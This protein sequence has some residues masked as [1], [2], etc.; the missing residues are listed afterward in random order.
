MSNL[1]FPPQPKFLIVS[2]RYIGDVL[3]ST[4]LALSIKTQLPE[5]AVDYL[6][7]KGTEGILD[8]NP[9]VRK[10]HTVSS[11]PSGVVTFLKLLRR[12]D[13]AIGVNPSDRTTI[14]TAGA[15]RCSIGFSY[16]FGREWWKKK[17]LTQ[18]RSY[19]HEQHIVPLML[20]QL[21]LLEIPAIGNVVMSF[22]NEDEAFVRGQLKIP[23]SGNYIL[24]HPYTRQSYKYWPAAS[25]VKLAGAIENKLGFKPIFTRTSLAADEEQFGRIRELAGSSIHVF[26][27]P[28]SLTQLAAAI[29]HAKAFVGVDT[30]ATH[31]AAALGVPMIALF[32]PTFVHNWG[33]WANG[34]VVPNPYERTGGIKTN[35]TITVVQQERECIPCGQQTCKISER[36]KIE[37]LETLAAE[38][39]FAE[40]KKLLNVNTTI[41][42]RT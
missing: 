32:G 24:L 20:T 21:E 14:Y 15:G 5:A 28:F 7:F 40:L 1:N 13:F 22:D 37:C 10:V 36:G 27:K 39:V 3:L 42:N 17:V 16:F 34:W 30:V 38:V 6:V 12:Y 11:G 25:W 23:E 29:H 26:P 2:L 4:P 8:K 18:C 35:G 31:M 19:A 9:Y 41:L 33:P